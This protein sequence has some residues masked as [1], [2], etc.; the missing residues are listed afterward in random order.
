MM[1]ALSQHLAD[2]LHRAGES[3]ASMAALTE[4]VSLF[5]EITTGGEEQWAEVWL[6]RW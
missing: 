2:G 1:A 3:E 6:L 5:T 4:A